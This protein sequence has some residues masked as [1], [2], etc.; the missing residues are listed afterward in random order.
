MGVVLEV[1][2]GAGASPQWLCQR[3]IAAG[4]RPI[5]IIVDIT[6]YVLLETGHPLHAFDLDKLSENRI[7]VRRA[8]PGERLRTLD[9]EERKLAAEML[10][11]ADAKKAQAVAGIMGG[12]D[13]EVGAGTRR[14]LLESAVFDPVSIR[15]TSRALGI[16]TE[17]SQRFQRGADPEMALF[18]AKRA[19]ALLQELTGATLRRG[20]LDE[21]PAPYAAR[22][23]E[24]RYA[25]C[26]ALLGVRIDADF[27]RSALEKLGFEARDGGASCAVRVPSWRHDVR[28][29]ADLIEEVARLYGYDNLA[30]TLPRVRPCETVLA[31]LEAKTGALRRFLAGQGLTEFYNW[32][33]CCREDLE[34]AA[35]QEVYTGIVLLENPLSEKQAGLRPTLLPS[36]LANAAHNIRHGAPDIAAFEI[37]PVYRPVAGEDL[38]EQGLRLGLVLSGAA[39][40]AHWSEA[41]R[42]HDFYDM[43]GHVEAALQ[44]LGAEAAFAE[45]DFGP[46]QKGQCAEIRWKKKVLGHFGKVKPGVM[47]AHGMEGQVFLLELDLRPLLKTPRDAA[48][49]SELPGFPASLRDMAVIVGAELP[50]GTLLETARKS[51]GKMLKS[52][53]VFDVYTGAQ[54]PAGKKSVALSLVF[55]SNERTL[56]DKDTQKSW[57]KILKRLQAEH[58]AALR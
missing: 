29:E 30:A 37:A 12:G 11:I 7:V 26:D 39:A 24:L 2:G 54:V 56:T 28:M 27:Q 25:R 46:F 13:S 3:L 53:E 10:V 51:G 58:E 18:A 32:S 21:Y 41:A 36:L 50:V 57:D 6:N 31:P 38:P 16:I 23:V 52:V 17:S 34:R 19:A 49:F 5:N 8:R 22:E 20:L 40:D 1:A 33:F 14:I 55:Q 15:R 35:L 44:H 47:K 45:A 42:A 4:Q 9:G 48:R 43:K